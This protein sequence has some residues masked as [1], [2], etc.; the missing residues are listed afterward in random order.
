MPRRHQYYEPIVESPEPLVEQEAQVQA[1]LRA[2]DVGAT[3]RY[4]LLHDVVTFIRFYASTLRAN[5]EPQSAAVLDDL[6]EALDPLVDP[7]IPSVPE[8]PP[9][10]IP[11]PAPPP[12]PP[13][14]VQYEPSENVGVY[15]IEVYPDD[16]DAARPKWFART[17]DSEGN[18]LYVTP[19]AFDQEYVIEDARS[20]WPD[21][22][23][24][25]VADWSVD[26]VWEEQDAGQGARGVF[27]GRR[28]PSPK[29][30]FGPV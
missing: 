13:K 1:S 16:P 21:V 10:P 8:E 30:M 11:P 9:V 23:I 18:I 7:E 27:T 19:G 22:T 5:L 17:V 29:R 24:Q 4:V 25:L 3:G 15:R 14:V 12:P 20:R 6:I 2:V 28:R 26:S